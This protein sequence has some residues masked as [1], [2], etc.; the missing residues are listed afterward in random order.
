MTTLH[1]IDISI[2]LNIIGLAVT[3]A[4]EAWRLGVVSGAVT[5]SVIWIGAAA[6]LG[7]GLLIKREMN[8]K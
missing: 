8:S 2:A 5:M 7:V 6:L 3:S 1:L 4:F